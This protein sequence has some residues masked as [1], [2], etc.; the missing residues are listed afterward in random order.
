MQVSIGRLENNTLTIADTEVSSQH[1]TIRWDSNSHHWQV[2]VPWPLHV[3]QA[4]SS[5]QHTAQLCRVCCCA[6]ACDLCAR[7]PI[8]QN[9]GQRP[10]QQQQQQQQ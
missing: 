6:D 8:M 5:H 9:F 10:L 2:G 7:H 1:V 4:A 3:W